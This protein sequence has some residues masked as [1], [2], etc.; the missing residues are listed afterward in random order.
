VPI[1]AFGLL[2]LCLQT[3][4]NVWMMSIMREIEADAYAASVI[5]PATVLD[6]IKWVAA[7]SRK[8]LTV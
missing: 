8:G 3:V 5:G 2:C 4:L 1:A 6:G 7:W